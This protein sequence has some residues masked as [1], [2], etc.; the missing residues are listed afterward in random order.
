MDKAPSSMS[1]R[2]APTWD[3][4]MVPSSCILARPLVRLG[5]TVGL[6]SILA[7]A[8]A[9]S[10]LSY[11]V[12]NN[13]SLCSMSCATLPWCLVPPLPED[14]NTNFGDKYDHSSY[15]PHLA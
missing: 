14:L 6:T 10:W 12:W 13:F 9:Q 15:F 4:G 5:A 1:A 8:S 7:L 11:P 2:M 3:S